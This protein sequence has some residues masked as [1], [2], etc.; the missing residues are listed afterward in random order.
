[1]IA[2]A[3]RVESDWFNGVIKGPLSTRFAAIF[4]AM[5]SK[6]LEER[7]EDQAYNG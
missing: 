4:K 5:Y 7:A 1:M 6:Y 2:A 3:F